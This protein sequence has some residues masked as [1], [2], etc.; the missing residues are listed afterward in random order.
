MGLIYA[1]FGSGEPPAFPPFPAFEGGV[2]DGNG[3]QG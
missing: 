1:Y 2:V 3:G